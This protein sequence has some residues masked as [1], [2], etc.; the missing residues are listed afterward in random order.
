MRLSPFD[1]ALVVAVGLAVVFGGAIG[2]SNALERTRAGEAPAAPWFVSGATGHGDPARA[3][4]D[5]YAPP[6]LPQGVVIDRETGRMA[7]L[8]L[9]HDPDATPLAWATIDIAYAD[10]DDVPEAV[11]AL[12]G[13]RVAI[14]GFLKAITEVTDIREFLLV[15]SH[16]ACCFG[17]IPGPGGMLMVELA[18]DQPAAEMTVAPVLVHGRLEIRPEW[19]RHGRRLLLVYRLVDARVE[20]LRG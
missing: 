8:R 9:P 4:I 13:E 16:L 12:A 10:T 3:G 19:S 17:R 15:G 18:P 7:G 20:L 5:P 2:I 6:G 1:L 14:A 11:R